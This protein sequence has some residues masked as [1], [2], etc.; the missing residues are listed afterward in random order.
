MYVLFDAML[1]G[2]AIELDG[3]L[4]YSSILISTCEIIL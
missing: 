1:S 3:C 4:M 2:A